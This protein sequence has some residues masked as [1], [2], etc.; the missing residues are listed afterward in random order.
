MKSKDLAVGAAC[1]L[2]VGIVLGAGAALLLAPTSGSETRRRLRFE[3]D[4]SLEIARSKARWAKGRLGL[5]RP[6]TEYG[7]DEGAFSGA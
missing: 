1:G 4:H 3:R 5:E 2:A 7:E 6:Q